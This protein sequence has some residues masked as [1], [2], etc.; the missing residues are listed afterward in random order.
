MQALLF[1]GIGRQA[2]ALESIKKTLF[3]NFSNFTCWHVYGIIY[4]KEKDY[5]QAKKAYLN[6]L[7]YAPDNENVMRDLCQMQ[8]HTR[9]YAGFAETRKKLMLKD[10]HRD[11]WTAFTTACYVSGDFDAC[12]QG[13]DSMLTVDQSETKKPLTPIQLM[14]IVVLK[15][16]A[17]IG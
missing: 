12:V 5:E 2:E 9:D 16:K 14:E 17:L 8:L 1:S 15:V 10:P 13:V 7:K 11:N 3:K 4:R 6:A